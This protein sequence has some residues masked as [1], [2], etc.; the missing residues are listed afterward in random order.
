MNTGSLII[1]L[2][3]PVIEDDEKTLL[4]HPLVGGV[5]LFSRNYQNPEQVSL[6]CKSIRAYAKKP[7]LIM[8]DQEGGRVQRFVNGF[9]R[10]P[11]LHEI[12]ANYGENPEQSIKDA[13]NWGYT[14]AQEMLSIGIDLSL[15]PIL[16]LNKGTS[17]VIGN[18]AFHA[19]PKVVYELAKAYIS[20]MNAAGMQATGKHFPG[21]GHIVTDSHLDLAQDNRTFDAIE[22][23]DLLPFIWLINDNI[24]A[25]M[26]A[27]I[28]FPAIDDF[29]VTYSSVWLKTILRDKFN[30]KGVIISDDLNMK[31][32]NITNNYAERFKLAKEA[33]CDLILLCNNR[34]AVLQVL[35]QYQTEYA[36]YL[37]NNSKLKALQ[38]DFTAVVPQYNFK[39]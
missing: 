16:D 4:T 13:K 17:A 25:L 22:R 10:L 1:D 18:R 8:V 38:A 5:I 2:K 32:A 24:A 26:S 27:H 30:F 3:G 37:L 29:P 34:P 15:A 33:G 7:V 39:H 14:M 31:G 11:A 21:H 9:S 36:P 28:L 23:E 6:L 12:A 20:G 35:K 19:D